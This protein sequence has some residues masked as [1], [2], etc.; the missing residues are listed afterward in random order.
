MF[1]KF[2]KT[3]TDNRTVHCEET[4]D[5]ASLNNLR[6]LTKIKGVI[7]LRAFRDPEVDYSDKLIYSV[8]KPPVKYFSKLHVPAKLYSVLGDLFSIVDDEDDP[9]QSTALLSDDGLDKFM[10]SE[11]LKLCDYLVKE[12][13]GV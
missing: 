10:G 2:F 1:D 5:E 11:L 13:N 8:G 3:R 9:E 7:N 6:V 12:R 4:G